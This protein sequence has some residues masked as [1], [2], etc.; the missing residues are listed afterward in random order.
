MRW[1]AA[2]LIALPMVVGA[3]AMILDTCTVPLEQTLGR[4]SLWIVALK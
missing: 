3:Q 4:K 2:L 1:F